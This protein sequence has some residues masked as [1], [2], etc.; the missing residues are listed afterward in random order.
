MKAYILARAV[1]SD[2]DGYATYSADVP[3]VVRRFGGRFLARGG[4]TVGLEG[5]VFEGRV[6]IIEF[7]DMAAAEGFYNSQ[8]YQT[9][10][11]RRTPF[12]S[13]EL[14]AVEGV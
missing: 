10:K 9:L 12:S 5:A 11:K 4:R 7:P 3:E 6:V 2:A 13:V 8:D 14:I 1:I